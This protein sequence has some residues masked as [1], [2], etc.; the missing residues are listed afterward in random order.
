MH[1]PPQITATTV[2]PARPVE[3]TAPPP[4]PK[5]KSSAEL[6][7]EASDRV[8]E[9]LASAI[10]P[11]KEQPQFYTH[12]DYVGEGDIQGMGGQIEKVFR[13]V[14]SMIDTVGLNARSLQS[15]L[16]GHAQLKK[17]GQR[18][19]KD[20]EDDNAWTLAEVGDLYRVLENIDEQLDKGKLTHVP[21]TLGRLQQDDEEVNK[22]RLRT[23]EMRRQISNHT[24]P[25]QKA[26]RDNHPL[27]AEAA[28]QQSDLRSS[29]QNVQKLLADVEQKAML[30]RAD[31][32]SLQSKDSKTGQATPVPTVEAVERTILKMTAMVQQ[33][34]ADVDLLERHVRQLP[35]GIGALRLADDY[36]DDLASRLG[37]SKL[38]T[39]SPGRR[40]PQK[41]P[42][43]AANG[44]ALGASA[45]FSVSRFST[46]PSASM[47]ASPSLRAS[48]LGRSGG[49]A[50][51]RST[52]SLS[53]SARKKMV[54]V[55]EEE[56]DAFRAK[57]Q[58]RRDVLSALSA[59]VE[60]RG[61]R[62]V[63]PA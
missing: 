33:K 1:L 40:T 62:V 2:P 49:S 58:R 16:E 9:L 52:G 50:L 38:L 26:E 13:D 37:G 45:M 47:R 10:E 30:L 24:D 43:M 51:G 60:A 14:N 57:T 5:E 21:E 3:R 19:V 18:D 23:K 39:D 7:D 56:V 12:S 4:Q 27:S 48:A 44:D 28:A 17:P 61:T 53:A 31:L 11:T 59:K 63:K 36:E 54:H 46:P 25:E 8:R 34:S 6:A 55:T 15:F 20:L 32:S 22:I 41:Y 35:G 29:L 42:R